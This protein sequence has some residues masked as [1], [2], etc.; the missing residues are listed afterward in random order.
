MPSLTKTGYVNGSDLLIMVGTKAIGH[1]T[2]HTTT[3]NSDTKDRA[4]KPLASQTITAGLWKAKS[5][6]G[7]SV[8]ISAEG[9]RFYNETEYGFKDLFKA[10]KAALPVT[11]K[12]VER[13]AAGGAEQTPYL[14][15]SFVI[16]SLE[17]DAPAAD[18]ATYKVTLENDGEPT[19][20][21]AGITEADS[22]S[23]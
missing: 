3:F 13:A 21:D 17:E 9:L 18:D 4:V 19:L 7:L 16:T 6:S 20:N 1:C 5:V 22:Q 23:S 12:A 8:S 14:S 10:W 11:V 15:G 2:T